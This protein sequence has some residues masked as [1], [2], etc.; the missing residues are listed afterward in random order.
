M[1]I[2]QLIE[3]LSNRVNRITSDM[4]VASQLGDVERVLQLQAEKSETETTI[5]QLRTLES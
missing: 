5:T 3:L 1:N 2:K 4:A